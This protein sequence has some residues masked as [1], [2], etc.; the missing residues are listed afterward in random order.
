MIYM[1]DHVCILLLLKH[2]EACSRA[3]LNLSEGHTDLFYDWPGGG[4]LH[5]DRLRHGHIRVSIPTLHHQD[6]FF[7]SWM[8]CH[9]DTVLA[10]HDRHVSKMSSHAL[11]T[12]LVGMKFEK[13]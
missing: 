10:L 4:N 12:Q 6:I 11:S 7:G 9:I 3:S 5:I 8:P 13:I 2:A 1:F